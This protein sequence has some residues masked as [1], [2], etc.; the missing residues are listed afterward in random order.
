MLLRR[1][2]TL[3]L[4]FYFS[5]DNFTLLLILTLCSSVWFHWYVQST[6]PLLCKVYGLF[7]LKARFDHIVDLLTEESHTVDGMHDYGV[8]SVQG[9]SGRVSP[10]ASW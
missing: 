4:L 2:L 8:W 5:I 3:N 10:K 6:G 7:S 9:I 1:N